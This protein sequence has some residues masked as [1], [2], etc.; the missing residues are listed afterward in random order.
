ME[1][2]WTVQELEDLNKDSRPHTVFLIETWLGDSGV[3]KLK[4]RFNIFGFLVA[5]RGRSGGYLSFG[6]RILVFLC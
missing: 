3:D 5:S 6:R 1:N 2:L 4:Q